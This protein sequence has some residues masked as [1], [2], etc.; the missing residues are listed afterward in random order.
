MKK[1]LMTVILLVTLLFVGNIIE[2]NA[3]DNSTAVAAA[4]EGV[5]DKRPC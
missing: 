3:S 1:M 5:D 4:D 2:A